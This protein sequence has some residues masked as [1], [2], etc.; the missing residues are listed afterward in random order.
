METFPRNWPFGRGIHQKAS[1][2][3][4][5]LMFS[6]ICVSINRLVNNREAGD[7]GRDRGHY[8]VAV[9]VTGVGPAL[10]FTLLQIRSR[11]LRPLCVSRLL[12]L[13]SDLAGFNRTKTNA[14]SLIVSKYRANITYVQLMFYHK[15]VVWSWILVLK[16][17]DIHQALIALQVR[18]FIFSI[19]DSC[20]TYCIKINYHNPS[21]TSDRYFRKSSNVR[22]RN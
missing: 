7:L 8:D 16:S 15:E 1:A 9:M 2:W 17:V 4:V 11:H 12:S 5:A 21:L 20:D 18:L 19:N 14:N 10:T 3:R 13:Y 22:D 6:L